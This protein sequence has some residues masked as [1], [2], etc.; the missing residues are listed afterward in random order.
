MNVSDHDPSNQLRALKDSMFGWIEH[1]SL[2]G[3]EIGRRSNL[4][5]METDQRVRVDRDENGARG[6]E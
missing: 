5:L 2:P 4:E 6:R 3:D 1:R